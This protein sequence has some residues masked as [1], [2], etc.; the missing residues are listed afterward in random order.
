MSLF[1]ISALLLSEKKERENKYCLTIHLLSIQQDK[2]IKSCKSVL[3]Y[4]NTLVFGNYELK[5]QHPR[6][7]GVLKCKKAGVC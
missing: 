2:H 3:A 5:L 7:M 1:S 6:R 4:T